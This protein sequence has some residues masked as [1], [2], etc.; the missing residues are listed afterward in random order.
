MTPPPISATPAGAEA[1]TRTA[2][3]PRRSAVILAGLALAVIAGLCFVGAL[4]A[5]FVWDDHTVFSQQLPFFDSPVRAFFPPP[6]VPHFGVVYYRPLIVLSWQ[7]DDVLA[8]SF[9]PPARLDVARQWTFHAANIALHVLATLLVYAFGLAMARLTRLDARRGLAIA[10]AAAL[11][12]AVHPAHAESVAWIAG[13]SDVLLAVFILSALL[14]KLRGLEVGSTLCLSLSVLFLAAAL[15]TKESAVAGLIL[16]PLVD[17]FLAPGPDAPA[18]AG[19]RAGRF[20]LWSVA[21]PFA[22]TIVCWTLRWSA[23]AGGGRPAAREGVGLGELLGATGWYLVK[24]VWPFHPSVYVPDVPRGSFIWLGVLALAAVAGFVAWALA[25]RRRR[26]PAEGL[27]LGLVVV[28]LVFTLSTVVFAVAQTPVA[29]RYLYL[30]S[31]GF[32]LLAA[33]LLDRAAQWTRLRRAWRM[34][35][36]APLLVA[37]VVSVPLVT[38]SLRSV[39]FWTNERRLWQEAAREAP[40]Q[41]LPHLH[42]GLADADDG[43][44][45]DAAAE[46][47]RALRSAGSRETYALAHDNLGALLL[48][49]SRLDEA[50]PHLRL[51]VEMDPREATAR[52]NLGRALMLSAPQ[53]PDDAARKQLLADAR[54]ELETALR[55]NPLYVRAHFQY[56][57]LLIRTGEVEQGL[58]HLK[59]GLRLEP[60]HPKADLAR[61]LIAE[62]EKSRR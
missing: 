22:A 35:G 13:R 21:A 60:N 24:L 28:P 61:Q 19:G 46:Y 11:L 33:F 7:L 36:A 29:E 56:G 17:L 45:D 2:P 49:Q 3:A 16:L 47:D 43:R 32:C 8:R 9:W 54:Q 31:A 14:A 1:S 38:V 53:A 48:G 10:A 51:A 27:A 62:T 39:G 26:V 44:K 18:A 55:L 23:L 59:E 40:G 52:Y 5:P 25:R 58:A 42:L 41:A 50:I 20:W 15:L 57:E 34:P 12:F 30:S 37:V 6:D 4:G